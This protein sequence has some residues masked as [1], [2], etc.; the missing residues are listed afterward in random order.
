MTFAAPWVGSGSPPQAVAG[1]ASPP[2]AVPP[3]VSTEAWPWPS[4]GEVKLGG[5]AHK[6]LFCRTLLDTFDPYRPAVIDW[7][8]LDPETEAR[9][10]GL[11]IWDI[12][13]QTENQAM[14]RVKAYADATRDPLVR[15]ALELN[16]FEEGRHKRV[17]S[18]MVEAYGV[19]L[20][21]ET[22]HRPPVDAEWSFMITGFGECIDSFVAFGLFE[23]ARRTGF[24]PPALVDTFER[25]IAEEGRHILFFVN[26]V[27]WRRRTMPWWRRPW[28]ELKVWTVWIALGLDRLSLVTGFNRGE[29]TDPGDD[30]VTVTAAEH[31]AVDV[32]L[33][34]LL[35]VCLAENDRRL[36]KYDPRLVRPTF[37]PSL[38]RLA[39]RLLAKAP[40]T[41]AA[42]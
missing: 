24:F 20:Q 35:D 1:A 15:K 14:R 19:E 31:L 22:P 11:P 17:L 12:A 6:R 9:L 26:W 10:T 36:G 25:V 34:Q 40:A 29:A 21:P 30:N 5:D 2:E 8:K 3:D 32:D 37:V 23:T 28:F 13:V 27:A 33:A 41:A 7:P 18:C 16:A 42:T 4:E 38:A 39:R